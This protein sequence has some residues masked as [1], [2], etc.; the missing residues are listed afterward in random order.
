M[1]KLIQS[2]APISAPHARVLILG[3]MPGERSLAASQYYANPRNAFWQVMQHVFGVDAT[4]AYEQR[5]EAMQVKGIAVWDVLRSCERSGSLDTAIRPESVE[6][7]DFNTFFRLHPHIATV[8]FNGGT[9]RRF[10][11][12]YVLPKLERGSLEYLSM[13]STSPTHASRSLEQ[14]IAAWRAGVVGTQAA[15]LQR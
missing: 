8:I 9:A 2:M 13:P 14:K 3:S 5:I 12:W 1:T 10:Y 11:R 7:N 6:I 4:L 15:A